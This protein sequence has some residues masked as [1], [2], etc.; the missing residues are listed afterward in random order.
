MLAMVGLELSENNYSKYL[1]FANELG[2]LNCSSE[3][4]I[5]GEIVL[6]VYFLTHKAAIIP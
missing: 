4:V 2:C 6:S 5:F 3:I 1:S